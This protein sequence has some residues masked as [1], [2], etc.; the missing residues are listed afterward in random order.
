MVEFYKSKLN[1]DEQNIYG[2]IYRAVCAQRSNLTVQTSLGA[3]VFQG[4]FESVLH[5]HPEQYNIS[6]QLSMA[7]QNNSYTL[8][9]IYL[10]NAAE[11]KKINTEIENFKI[12]LLREGNKTLLDR[13]LQVAH[14]IVMLSDYMIDNMYNQNIAS[15][16]FNHRAQ[17]SGFARTFQFAMNI[18]GVWCTYVAGYAADPQTGIRSPHAWN[19]VCF[20]NQYYHVDTTAMLGANFQ[21]KEPLLYYHIN[22]SD[23]TKARDGCYSWDRAFYPVCSRD[24]EAVGSKT[25]SRLY[26][27]NQYFAE[28]LK[29]RETSCNFILNI[30]QYDSNK[31]SQMI[32]SII[33]DQVN[34]CQIR[35][36]VK[37]E[38]RQSK[39]HVTL[40]YY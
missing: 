21:K 37:I 2:Q 29:K 17:C 30:P 33:T 12:N 26:D 38:A 35:V 25:F 5:D 13:E 7:Y 39:F 6:P 1:R 24:M 4:I 10:Y 36:N 31:L 14:D 28:C 27:L 23:E 11:Q 20:D 40:T 8:E 18:L 32:M 19:I 3:N 15:V 9:F 16:L 34:N 22:C